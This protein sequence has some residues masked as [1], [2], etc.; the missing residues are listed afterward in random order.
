[1]STPSDDLNW[2]RFTFNPPVQYFGIQAS[3]CFSCSLMCSK[4][5]TTLPPCLRIF[6]SPQLSYSWNIKCA[7]SNFRQEFLISP[8][9]GMDGNFKCKVSQV[10]FWSKCILL[11]NITFELHF[12]LYRMCVGKMNFYSKGF[13]FKIHEWSGFINRRIFFCAIW[14]HYWINVN[15]TSLSICIESIF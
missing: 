10:H 2:Q 11:L 9:I 6:F 1:M 5:I 8:W 15:A 14:L 3:I 4:K 13:F 7:V 12:Q